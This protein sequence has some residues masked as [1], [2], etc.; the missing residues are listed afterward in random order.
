L[1]FHNDMCKSNSVHSMKILCPCITRNIVV[2]VLQNWLCFK[3]FQ[4]ILKFWGQR[5]DR[6]TKFC[7]DF[8]NRQTYFH[9]KYLWGL[10]CC[11]VDKLELV[12]ALS[13]HELMELI[14]LHLPHAN[15]EM[16]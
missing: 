6:Y 12:E 2:D 11:V 5:E 13:L 9:Y 1:M 3:F 8:K 15:E 4:N 16:M 14:C 7:V 10:Y